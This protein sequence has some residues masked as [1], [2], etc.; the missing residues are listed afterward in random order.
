M[1]RGVE[2]GGMSGTGGS[3]TEHANATI[4]ITPVKLDQAKKISHWLLFHCYDHHPFKRVSPILRNSLPFS[5]ACYLVLQARLRIFPGGSRGSP[6][7]LLHAV[8]IDKPLAGH[9]SQDRFVF[10]SLVYTA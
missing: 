10:E 6:R 2:E 7:S 8:D 5:H 3:E 1:L 4:V 9:P